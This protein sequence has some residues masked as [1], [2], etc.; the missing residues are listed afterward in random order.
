M[1]IGPEFSTREASFFL[2]ERFDLLNE[3][4]MQDWELM[5][6]TAEGLE[7]YVPF[8][9]Q[10]LTDLPDDVKFTLMALILYCF[11]ELL[12]K[13][14]YEE[15]PLFPVFEKHWRYIRQVLYDEQDFYF[16]LIA[17]QYSIEAETFDNMSLLTP[18]IRGIPIRADLIEYMEAL[19]AED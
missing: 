3:D 15:A 5:V 9:R 7:Q 11:E 10:M 6:A 18:F 8:F 17:E 2:S 19:A 16:H 12:T 4:Y 14:S 13:I 1:K